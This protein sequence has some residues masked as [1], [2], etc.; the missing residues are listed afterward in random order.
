MRITNFQARLIIW[1][2]LLLLFLLL[3]YTTPRHLPQMHSSKETNLT[4]PLDR[5]IMDLCLFLF[6]SFYPSLSL[7]LSHSSSL[8][9]SLPL[10]LPPSPL[11]FLPLSPHLSQYFTH[12]FIKWTFCQ[13]PKCVHFFQIWSSVWDPLW[14]LSEN[15]KWNNF[16]VRCN[17]IGHR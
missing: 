10:S 17:Q 2:L 6:S 3:H 4:H 1:I 5:S 12:M 16:S 8:S 11:L 9:H 15:L 7:S 14:I 13:W